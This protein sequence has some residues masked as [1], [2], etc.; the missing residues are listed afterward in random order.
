MPSSVARG[1]QP[2]QPPQSRR[3]LVPLRGETAEDL[4]EMNLG[5]AGLRILAVLPVHEQDAHY[6]RPMRRA[7]ASSTPFTNFALCTVPYRSARCTASW[8]TTRGGVSPRCSSAARGAARSGRSTPSRSRRQ[9]VVTSASSASSSVPCCDDRADEQRGELALVGGHGEVVPDLRG[10]ALERFVRRAGPTRTAPAG[11]ARARASQPSSAA[12]SRSNRSAISSAASAASQPLLPC[13]PPA[14]A[15][16]CS[17]LSHVSTPNPIGVSNSALARGEP[18]RR[19]AG[20]VVEVRRVA[21]NH[22]ADGDERVVPLAGRAGGA[23][24]SAA[25]TRRAPRRRRRR[26]PPTPCRT[27]ASSAPST[28][29]STIS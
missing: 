21:A 18:A 2:G 7:S 16:A 13:A 23:R 5:A 6:I 19:F 9:L 14:R 28:S 27:S 4:V 10:D 17:S 25:P 24:R 8:I 29:R 26:R 3:D 12:S 22:R 20:D 1:G 15:S 11:R